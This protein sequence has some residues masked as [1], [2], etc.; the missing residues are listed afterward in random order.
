M[1]IS[2][3][4]KKIVNKLIG[5]TF[6]FWQMLG[7]HI[8]P[9]HFYEPIPDTRRLKKELWQKNSDMIGISLEEEKQIE[10]LSAFVKKFK[11]EYDLF[12]GDKLSGADGVN[13]KNSEFN[14]VDAEILYCMVR[15]LKPKNIIEI[16]SGCS[17]IIMAKAIAKNKDE[18]GIECKLTTIDP[19]LKK[20]NKNEISSSFNS[21]EKE[22]QDVRLDEFNKL[23]ENDI[24]FIDSSHVLKIGS[25]VQYEYLEI[26]PRLN[27]GVVVHSHDVFLPTEYPK[28]WVLK[29]HRFF[30][31]Q[32]LLQAF[33]AFNKKFEVLWGGSYMHLK[34]KE[35]L[36]NAFNSYNPDVNW[37]GS[38]W[39]K[40][41]E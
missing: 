2:V 11:G 32:Y 20:F 37:P 16:G 21:I 12:F 27:K 8:T 28:E 13:I 6:T 15:Y 5:K 38:F 14:S 24:L 1:K 33:L 40:K 19:Y 23:R 22:V 7:F 18:F 25:D 3:F 36:K 10:L 17:T 30:N 26:L 4:Y 35:L 39:M 29:E 34:H 31:E 41:I 9:V